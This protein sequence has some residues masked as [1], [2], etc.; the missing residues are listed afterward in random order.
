MINGSDLLIPLRF[1]FC[2][3][4]YNFLPLC[5]LKNQ[6]VYIKLYFNPQSWFTNTTTSFDLKNVSIIYDTIFLTKQERQYYTMN[7][8]TYTIPKYY[9]ETPMDFT[10]AYASIN[11]TANFNVSMIIW[12][13]RNK[14]EYLGDYSKRYQYGYITNLVR[15]YTTYTDWRGNQQYYQQVFND[16]QIFINNRNIVSGIRDDLYYAYRQ[17]MQHGLSVPDKNIYTYCFGDD[18]KSKT[19]N[20]F[21]NFGLYPSK[22][23]NMN[24]L[25]SNTLTA[26]L[27]K[28]FQLWF[29][30]YGVTQITFSGGFGTVVSLQ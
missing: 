10:N 2:N 18:V 3:K 29:Y 7:P 21:I 19:N 30:Y 8:I 24:I 13:I 5:A 14:A 15:S 20:G 4:D 26:E 11:L 12:F 27:V 1:F 6:K 22:S 25:F 9:K 17:P 28:Y 23:T 16:L